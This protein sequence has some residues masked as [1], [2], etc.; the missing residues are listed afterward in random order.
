MLYIIN[1]TILL[2]LYIINVTTLFYIILL[3]SLL[4]N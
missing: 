2:M 3:S 4:Q 1:V